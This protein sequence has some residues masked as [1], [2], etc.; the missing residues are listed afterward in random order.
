NATE[1]QLRTITISSDP[2]EL[3]ALGDGAVDEAFDAVGNMLTDAGKWVSA[4]HQFNAAQF[5]VILP[6]VNDIPGHYLNCSFNQ[7]VQATYG[8]SLVNGT[9]AAKRFAP[10]ANVIGTYLIYFTFL[11]FVASTLNE[12]GLGEIP[13]Q[14]ASGSCN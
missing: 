8:M 2:D 6:K 14:P 4:I 7:Y 10:A 11:D 12:W 1:T 5:M 3:V 9:A 13:A